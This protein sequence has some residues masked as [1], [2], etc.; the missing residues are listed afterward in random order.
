MSA[1]TS[2]D[3]SKVQAAV[4]RWVG[5]ETRQGFFVTDTQLRVIVWNRWME[6]HSGH[7][8]AE[9]MGRSLFDVYKDAVARGIKEYYEQAL[10]GHVT[11]ISHAL[12]RYILPMR[13]T[14]PDLAFNEMPQSGHIGP[15]S[16][17][18]AV[19][20]TVT[21][22]EDVSD[23]LSSEAQLRKQIAALQVARTTAENALRA[24]DEFLSTL[25]HEIRTPLS[26]VLGWV[27]ILL[28]RQEIDRALLD[29]GLQVIE[30]NATAQAKIIDDMLDMARIV[31]GK[32]R[33]EKQPVRLQTV[34]PTAIDGIMPAAIA[35]GVTVRTALN[36]AT[37]QVN[38]DPDRLQQIVWN[39]ISNA[40]KFTEAGGTIDVRLDVAG[41]CARISV[42]DTGQG[43]SPEFL[44]SVFERFRQN[45][46]SSTR[47]HGGLG[48]GLAL[49]RELVELHGGSVRAASAGVDKGSTFTIDLPAII[50]PEILH[51]EPRHDGDDDVDA[52]LIG[53]RVLVVEDEPDAREL[54]VMALEHRGAEVTAVP[55]SSAGVSAILS[56]SPWALPH[57]L[58]SDI[59][60][61]EENGYDFI[62]RVRALDPNQG[63][64]IPAVSVTAYT[65]PKEIDRAFAAGYQLHVPKPMDP[66][67]LVKAVAKLVRRGPLSRT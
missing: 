62:K 47:R 46:A 32:L 67:A 8:A 66:S 19:I 61:P 10:A 42:T 41:T 48:L 55:S 30:R 39:L 13:P 24:K 17:G 45:D 58:V 26:A 2:L 57:V 65:T 63:G 40:I 35:K 53:V 18:G 25:S 43:I 14:H 7:P 50:S 6:L 33:L 64:R 44:P 60:M 9:M 54:A 51:A 28:G 22:V 21:I 15:L 56:S 36:P 27:R 12:H 31:A 37:P 59:G 49:V 20:G 52:S 3:L 16:H 1:E 11:V 4:T 29:R 34:V 38:G 5:D 23:P